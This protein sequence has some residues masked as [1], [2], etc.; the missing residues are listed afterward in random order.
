MSFPGAPNTGHTETRYVLSRS[1]RNDQTSNHERG[2][3]K[4]MRTSMNSSVVIWCSTVSLVVKQYWKYNGHLLGSSHH[5]YVTYL[6]VV[7]GGAECEGE[8]CT[9]R[10]DCPNRLFVRLGEFHSS[11]Q[12]IDLLEQRS[13]WWHMTTRLTVI[14]K[15]CR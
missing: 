13:S 5:N 4:P 11:S 10:Q 2:K 14:Y 15:N 1:Y 3:H 9:A 6:E 8:S 7:L 12:L